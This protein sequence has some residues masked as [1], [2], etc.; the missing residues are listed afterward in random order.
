M[1]IY[2]RCLV[3]LFLAVPVATSAVQTLHHVRSSMRG[4]K[5]QTALALTEP[6]RTL[7]V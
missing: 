1:R 4:G 6:G 5:M 7:A 2:A 3:V